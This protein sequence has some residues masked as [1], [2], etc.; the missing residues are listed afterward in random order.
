MNYP[1]P[2]HHLHQLPPL[3]LSPA[4]PLFQPLDRVL[5]HAA[6][7]VHLLTKRGGLN[8]ATLKCALETEVS[9][10]TGEFTPSSESV[11]GL[12]P[13]H[14]P[15]SSNPKLRH[16]RKSPASSTIQKKYSGQPVTSALAYFRE[17]FIPVFQTVHSPIKDLHPIMGFNVTNKCSGFIKTV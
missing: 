15:D 13:H 10:N 2:H 17:S 9:E 4:L 3:L 14:P 11:C 1:S 16:I 7:E 5:R 6:N 8:R 12:H